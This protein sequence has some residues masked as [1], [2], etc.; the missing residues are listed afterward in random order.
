MST[1]RATY[2]QHGSSP[3]PNITL[4]A[5][6]QVIVASGI[7]SSGTFAAPSGSVSAPG[8]Y[9][10]GDSN[11]GLYSPAADT[12]A[13]TEG[14]VE[15]LR[16]DSSGRVGIGTTSVNAPLHV[17]N[18]GAAGLEFYPA[19]YEIQAYN[20]STSAYGLARYNA[21]GHQFAVSA[22]EAARIDSSGRLLVGTSSS[23]AS[24]NSRVQIAGSTFETASQAIS[25][26]EASTSGA[27]LYLVK[28]RNGTV[29]SNT[30]VQNGD[31]L[32]TIQYY[33]ADGNGYSLGASIDAVVDGTPG[34]G[35]LPTR[36][37]FSTTADGASSPT[38]RMR[39][40][41]NGEITF[42]A[43]D[44][45]AP[46]VIGG[47]TTNSLYRSGT[48]MTG[49]HFS[50]N[51]W[52]PTGSTGQVNDNNNTL[53]NASHRMSVIYAGTG[54]INTSDTTLKQDIESLDQVE[55][56]V[57]TAIK[58]LIKKFRFIDAVATK[59]D[60]ARIHVGVIAQEI[61]QAF[62]DAGLDPR[63]YGLFCE[64]ALEDGSKRLGIRYDELL[65]FVIAAL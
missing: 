11:T 18:G 44:A 58:G 16:I 31:T 29:G 43:K 52:L 10:V 45:G 59:G 12:L 14:G 6:G 19:T 36:L 1:I 8:I 34:A 41:N 61:E 32:G 37:V 33:G 40:S 42:T 27:G 21:A 30:I 13:F 57:A 63:R 26:F 38:E 53:G 35:D 9:F 51:A 28:S 5:S 22:S 49:I 7:V 54:T 64:D 15:A 25:R 50:T 47:V 20:R 24:F 39:I 55:L 60:D 17:S 62:L 46:L 56:N 65:A 3:V 48:G 2:V 4:N 23:S